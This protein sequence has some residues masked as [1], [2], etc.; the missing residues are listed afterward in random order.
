MKLIHKNIKKEDEINYLS[1]NK[2]LVKRMGLAE[3][4]RL[5]IKP[6]TDM[7]F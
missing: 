6:L 1:Q 2:F 7:I 3:S 5:V 4:L